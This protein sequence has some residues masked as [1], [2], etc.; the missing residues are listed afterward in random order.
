MVTSLWCRAKGRRGEKFVVC[1]S[2]SQC[3][4]K[5]IEHDVKETGSLRFSVLDSCPLGLRDILFIDALGVGH[6]REHQLFPFV[7]LEQLMWRL[8]VYVPGKRR[9]LLSVAPGPSQNKSEILGALT[10]SP[11]YHRPRSEVACTDHRRRR[12]NHLQPYLDP[13]P[14]YLANYSSLPTRLSVASGFCCR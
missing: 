13:F 5:M 3:F 7:P 6:C 8:V 1:E 4:I 11:N 12:R 10:Y 2:D 14:T 9:S